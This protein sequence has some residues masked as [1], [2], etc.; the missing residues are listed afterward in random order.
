MWT[1]QLATLRKEVGSKR[2]F[3]FEFR[4]HVEVAESLDL[5]D[6]ESA[7]VVSGNKFYYL[8]NEAALLELAL[9]NWAFS[10][11]LA[12]GFTP[13]MTPDLVRDTVLEKCGFQPRMT[14]TQTYSVL[15][16]DLCLTVRP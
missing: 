5:V 8:R 10:K 11:V 13:I 14:N 6:F 16:S 12:K 7:A 4:N 2:E 1:L 9:I 15:D 3:D